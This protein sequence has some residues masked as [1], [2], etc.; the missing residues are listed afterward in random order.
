MCSVIVVLAGVECIGSILFDHFCQNILYSRLL[1][2]SFHRYERSLHQ[3]SRIELDSDTFCNL[4]LCVGVDVGDGSCLAFPNHLKLNSLS[5]LSHKD[6]KNDIK[7]PCVLGSRCGCV[8]FFCLE[9]DGSQEAFVGDGSWCVGELGMDGVGGVGGCCLRSKRGFK[10]GAVV[11]EWLLVVLVVVLDWGDGLGLRKRG[12]VL[13]GWL[14]GKSEVT[15]R[16]RAE[17]WALGLCVSGWRW[18]RSEA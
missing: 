13:S 2:L 5:L 8:G 11:R 4:S 10:G 6:L 18:E 15:E 7:A 12:G 9:E 17:E 1:Q 14:L 16:E 3:N